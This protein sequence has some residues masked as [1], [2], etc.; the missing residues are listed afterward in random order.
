MAI[1]IFFIIYLVVMFLL[2]SPTIYAI[3]AAIFSIPLFFAGS[4]DFGLVKIAT[5]FVNNSAATT[6]AALTIVLF[7]ISGDIMSQGQI[8]EKYS[9]Y[10]PISWGKSAVSC[11]SSAS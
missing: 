8:T 4:V 7:M 10:L 1:A 6:S 3:G 5:A 2:G 9:T 11:R